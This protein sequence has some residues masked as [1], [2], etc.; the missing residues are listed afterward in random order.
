M[1]TVNGRSFPAV[2]VSINVDDDKLDEQN[3]YSSYVDAMYNAHCSPFV[4]PLPDIALK[5]SYALL[6]EA[7]MENMDGL[8]LTGGDDVDATLYGDV[9]LPFNGAF[10]EERDLFEIELCRCAARRKKPILGICRGIQILN[11]SMGGTLFQDI[12]K[13][14]PEKAILMHSQRAPS[15][16]CVHDVTFAADSGLGRA[17]LEPGEHCGPDG[18]DR[19]SVRVNSFHHQAVRS[20]APGFVASAFSI[21]GVIEAIEPDSGGGG[22]VHPFTIGVQWHPERMWR[23]HKSAERLF[24]EF[25]SAC[26]GKVTDS[27]LHVQGMRMGGLAP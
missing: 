27:L 14:N 12:A 21:D 5:D 2:G 3:I 1:I 23:H 7:A 9:N 22:D 20:V 11:V 17:I 26:R 18:S 24:I 10:S 15:Y 13:Q 8:L 25:A 4:I 16:S 19:A 6:A